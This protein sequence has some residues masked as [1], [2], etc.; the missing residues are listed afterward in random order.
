MQ[1]ELERIAMLVRDEINALPRNFNRGKELYIGAD[2][3]P[4]SS[5]DK[6]AEDVILA[7]VE[8]MDLP[9]NILSEE[10]GAV[11]RGFEDT[12]VVDPIDGTHNSVLGVPL[13][14]VS[15]AVG[16][17]S[18]LGVEHAV[19]LDLA[20]DDLYLA[21]KGEGATMNG[22]A[23]RVRKF[24]TAEPAMLFYLGRFVHPRTFELLKRSSRVR[25]M[26]CA[27]LEMSLV[28]RGRF[29]AYYFNAEIYE[30][31]IRVV[32]IAAS[33]L[34]LREAGG[35]IVDLDG[36]VLDMPFDL[37]ARSNFL[38]YGDERAKEVLL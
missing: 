29:D 15:L 23:L 31:G 2:G 11:D 1:Q 38:A 9:V 24:K 28:A 30:K 17:K 27:S 8:D 5:I 4:T 10:A 3:T 21:Q 7:A 35:E 33:A 34:I 6:V 13:F 16:K 19:L 25:A 12:L 26:G 22:R 36:N 18:L 37:G 32:D 20:N 14:S